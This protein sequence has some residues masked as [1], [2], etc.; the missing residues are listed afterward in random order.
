M[1]EDRDTKAG[2]VQENS[3]EQKQTPV[4]GKAPAVSAPPADAA[5]VAEAPVADQV[6]EGYAPDLLSAQ[7]LVEHG[8]ELFGQP[9]YIVSTAI[10]H[11]GADFMTVDDARTAIEALLAHTPTTTKES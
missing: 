8:D 9:G 10:R 4:T 7:Q 1:A 11:A 3:D 5:P 6:E 2:A